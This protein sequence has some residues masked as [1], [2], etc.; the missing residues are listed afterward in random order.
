MITP[1]TSQFGW[2]VMNDT[3]KY[4][5]GPYYN[6]PGGSPSTRSA[7]VGYSN[8][9]N[10]VKGN[11]V[12]P[13]PYYR[14]IGRMW[15]LNKIDVQ[16]DTHF[17]V[18]DKSYGYRGIAM[19]AY[20]HGSSYS[21]SSVSLPQW[22]TDQVIQN[23]VSALNGAVANIMEDFGQAKQ[24]VDLLWGILKKIV[25]AYKLL[26]RHNWRALARHLNVPRPKTVAQAWLA[27]YYGIKPLVGTMEALCAKH[28][29]RPK[30]VTKRS[31]VSNPVD[32]SG[33]VANP[34]LTY[35]YSGSGKQ[36]AEC[37]MT[38]GCEISS[39]LSYWKSL[40]LSGPFG[41]ATNG[42]AIATVWA[43]TPYSFIVDWVLPIERFLRTRSWTSGVKYQHGYVTK[44]LVGDITVLDTNPMTGGNDHGTL[45]K[46][47]I[48]CM[49]M[50]R[51]AYN[52]F[53]PP[54][55]LNVKLSLT[56]TQSFNALALT[57][58]KF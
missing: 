12:T 26:R 48:G 30:T 52:V 49:Q 18:A 14:K 16:T 56:S 35:H 53:A 50:Q 4:D 31:R 25:E 43:L 57:L 51:S 28:E 27:Y 58:A 2:K 20:P 46:V 45:P 37:Q 36:R 40:G 54:S 1:H 11:G 21:S 47:R 13:L 7:T 29:P 19:S 41:E 55:G 33:F 5:W 6:Y 8:R 42:D 23:V 9:P 22:M 10:P 34:T 3:Q 39:D 44:S 38:V 32:P 17:L 15:S 24:T